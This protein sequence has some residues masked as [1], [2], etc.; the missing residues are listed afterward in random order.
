MY[1]DELMKNPD[2]YCIFVPSDR[3]LQHHFLHAYHD[4]PMCMHRGCD[5]IYN[6]LSRDCY[7]RNLSKHV[8]N[9]VRHCQHCIRFKSLQPAHGPMPVRLYQHPFHTFGVD[10]VCELPVSRNGNKWILT[11][12]CPFSNYLCANPVPDKTATTAANALFTDVFLLLGFLSVL[13]W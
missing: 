9:C 4:S 12:G 11:A 7:W 1:R 8:C 10:Y 5:A 2:H 13:W 6:A 3:H